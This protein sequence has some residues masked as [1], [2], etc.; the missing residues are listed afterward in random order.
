MGGAR[1]DVRAVAAD[2]ST[3]AGIEA[4]DQDDQAI[5]GREVIGQ[6]QTAP[7]SGLGSRLRRQVIDRLTHPAARGLAAGFGTRIPALADLHRG[8]RRSPLDARHPGVFGPRR[9]GRQG[10]TQHQRQNEPMHRI[11]LPTYSIASPDE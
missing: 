6:P 1:S 8:D 3:M 2:L 10:E 11:V 5:I 4:V 9:L 7:G